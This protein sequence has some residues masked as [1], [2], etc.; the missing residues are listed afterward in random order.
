MIVG[1]G[2]TGLC[3]AYLL[4]NEPYNLRIVEA[5]GRLGGRILTKEKKGLAPIEMGATWLQTF[6]SSLIGL[7]EEFNI[8]LFEHRVGAKAI[9]EPTKS[10]AAQL[11]SLPPNASPSF[12]IEGGTQVLIDHLSKVLN[13]KHVYLN[14]KLLSI[15]SE[16]DGLL[17]KC[18][19]LV[20]KASRVIST[21]PPYLFAK[22]IS[23]KP[24]L[25]ANFYKVALRTHTWMG[26]SIKIGL[27]YSTAFWREGNLTGTIFS[28]VGPIQEMYDHSNR[29]NNL[30]A[31]KGFVHSEF[32]SLTKAERL[33][34][35]L[36]QLEK[37]YGK[38]VHSYA[39]YEEKLWRSEVHTFSDYEHPVAAHENN[40]HP[41]FQVSYLNGRLFIAGA[42]TASAYPGYMEGAIR[43]AQF[44][45]QQILDV[46]INS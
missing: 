16:Q 39:H 25:D 36:E 33:K 13:P 7:L 3:I 27:N 6:H 12:R 45:S 41:V 19:D 30:F 29:K 8:Y 21:L 14:Q 26:E 43:S 18:E 10:A 22:N 4:R 28:N 15:G 32:Y 5:R 9:Y 1:G 31:L 42:E 35:V 34:L 37:Y 44:V 24:K 20:I 17:I 23:V 46:G 38:Q 11:V 40:G 2:L